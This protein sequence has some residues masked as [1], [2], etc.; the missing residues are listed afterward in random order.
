MLTLT[1][2][3]K[4]I[5]LAILRA[6]RCHRNDLVRAGAI[7]ETVQAHTS[8]AQ[9]DVVRVLV[10]M[11]EAGELYR[12]ESFAQRYFYGIAFEKVNCERV[13]NTAETVERVVVD[14]FNS[15]PSSERRLLLARLSEIVDEVSNL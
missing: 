7:V 12:T 1:A 3:E 13:C 5:R 9:I 2:K 6:I 14:A 4:E 10:K 8:A 15:L 11:H